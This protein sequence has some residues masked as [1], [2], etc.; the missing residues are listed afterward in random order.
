MCRANSGPPPSRSLTHI[1]TSS[2]KALRTDATRYRVF[3]YLAAFRM[4][5][6]GVA[7]FR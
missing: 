6:L 3:C 5:E 2:G 1:R 7:G 4:E